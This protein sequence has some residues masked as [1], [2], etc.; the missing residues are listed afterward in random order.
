S[1]KMSGSGGYYKYR[2]KYFLTHNC[3]HWVWVHNA[4]CAYC[5]AEGR[6]SDVGLMPTPFRL[7]QEVYV[8][9]LENG[10]LHYIIMEII[11]TSDTDSG[12]VV[13]DLPSQHFPVATG[14]SAVST[15]AI[16]GPDNRKRSKSGLGMHGVATSW[17]A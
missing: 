12:W 3:P 4:P 17:A 14:P 7:S 8:P 6:D 1:P 16:D 5:L 15:A 10:A 13:K 2:C 9:H 11:A